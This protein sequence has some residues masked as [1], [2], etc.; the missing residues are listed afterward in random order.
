[1]ILWKTIF[2]N[3]KEFYKL[4]N[5]DNL[6]AC[7]FN[8]KNPFSKIILQKE[9]NSVFLLVVKVR[10]KIT[11]N[12]RKEKV[13][14]RLRFSTFASITLRVN[15]MFVAEYLGGFF[16]DWLFTL[17]ARNVFFCIFP[18]FSVISPYKNKLLFFKLFIAFLNSYQNKNLLCSNFYVFALKN[19]K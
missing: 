13:L 4:V 2:G 7:I 15:A 10:K 17:K 14:S 11:E 18:L 6:S 9:D 12:S 16:Y 19:L 5:F 8:K 1:M 3:S